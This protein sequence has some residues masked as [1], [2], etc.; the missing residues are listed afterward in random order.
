M[1]AA[2]A[3]QLPTWLLQSSLGDGAHTRDAFAC[4]FAPVM[5]G[6][7]CWHLLNVS[8]TCWAMSGWVG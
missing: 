2:M 1:N 5:P 8:D 7:A 3:M 4:I 6:L